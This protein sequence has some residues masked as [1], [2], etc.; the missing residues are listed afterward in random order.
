LKFLNILKKILFFKAKFCKKFWLIFK[1]FC[2]VSLKFDA[3]QLSKNFA[4]L[5]EI[6]YCYCKVYGFPP[7]LKMIDVAAG[8]KLL[9]TPTLLIFNRP[10]SLNVFQI[11]TCSPVRILGT[12][13]QLYAIVTMALFIPWTKRQW[14]I[15]N[16]DHFFFT[17]SR[18]TFFILT[19]CF[20]T[21]CSVD[22]FMFFF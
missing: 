9:S 10:T 17:Y 12:Y 2:C 14:P 3:A 18:L 1:N 19:L 7:P 16:C 22:V 8:S 15:V 13:L 6:F 4:L 11:K 20:L 21:L 5:F